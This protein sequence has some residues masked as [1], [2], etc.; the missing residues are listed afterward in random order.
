LKD[1]RGAPDINSGKAGF[2]PKPDE[3]LTPDACP[4]ETQSVTSFNI[5][6]ENLLICNAL[7]G[8]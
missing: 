8:F 3:Y 2:F 4:V 7:M 1:P 5:L 6:D